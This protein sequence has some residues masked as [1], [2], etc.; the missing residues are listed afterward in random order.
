MNQW[1]AGLYGNQGISGCTLETGHALRPRES[2]MVQW[3]QGAQD[4]PWVSVLKLKDIDYSDQVSESTSSIS[5]SHRMGQRKMEG[6]FLS[7]TGTV[8]GQ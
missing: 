4:T 1:Q 5:P 3:K 8:C 6:P 2:I 7:G